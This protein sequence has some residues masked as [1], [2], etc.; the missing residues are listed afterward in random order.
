MSRS[1]S[2]PGRQTVHLGRW[3]TDVETELRSGFKNIDIAVNLPR[4]TP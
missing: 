3:Q 1:F 2:Q 4:K